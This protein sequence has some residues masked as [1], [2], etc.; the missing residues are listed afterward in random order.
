MS[1]SPLIKST[2]PDPNYYANRKDPITGRQYRICK[3]T[4]HHAASVGA[5]AESVA[6][7]LKD[8]NP[9]GST[10]YAIGNDGGICLCVPEENAA[11][12]SNSKL[13]DLQAVNIEVANVKGA[14]NWEISDVAYAQLIN[15][16][17]DICR[18][19]GMDGLTWT[20]DSSGTLTCHYM[21]AATACPGAYLK[22][23][24]PKIAE[25]V[26]RRVRELNNNPSAGD[27]QKPTAPVKEEPLPPQSVTNSAKNKYVPAHYKE[28][29][30][31]KGKTLVVTPKVGLNC[32]QD[33][34][35]DDKNNIITTFPK[36]TKL[37]WY[38][39]YNVDR[40]G[41]RWLLVKGDKGTGYCMEC[42]LK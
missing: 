42:Y 38:G 31:E 2:I 13:N 4:I 23:K 39:Y 9:K 16:C 14:P 11:W 10:N 40:R 27:I 19:N 34:N 32:R 7:Y 29:G 21:F 8:R 6:R 5:T 25:E 26:T 24:M 15:L 17:V 37:K 18:R 12:T 30:Y 36:G 1:N 41:N 33:T 20:G 22:S 35:I 28:K 3:I